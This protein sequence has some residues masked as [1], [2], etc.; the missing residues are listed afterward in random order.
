MNREQYELK[1]QLLGHRQTDL[2]PANRTNLK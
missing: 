2:P 1:Q